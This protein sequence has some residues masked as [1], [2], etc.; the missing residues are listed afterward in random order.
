MTKSTD[1][2]FQM[3]LEHIYPCKLCNTPNQ[4]CEEENSFCI[5]TVCGWEDDG[6]QSDFP[7]ELGANNITFEDAKARWERGEAIYPL[8]P[9]PNPKAA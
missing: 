9:N 6:V 1:P 4:C 7:N 5:C 2:E 8:F 3:I